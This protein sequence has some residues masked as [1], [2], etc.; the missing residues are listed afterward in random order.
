MTLAYL[1][2]LAAGPGAQADKPV[3]LDL[4]GLRQV[5]AEIET[6]GGQY[7]VKTRMLPVTVFDKTTNA[8]L[9][10]QKAEQYALQALARYLSRAR[11]SQLE[12]SGAR[13]AAT[14][15]AG[16]FYTLTLTA[17]TRGVKVVQATTAPGKIAPGKPVRV[18]FDEPFFTR[19]RDHLDTL[20]RLVAGLAADLVAA[21]E[22]VG[23]DGKGADDFLVAVADLE[24][25][26]D[27]CLKKLR[28]E[29]TGDRLLLTVER[30]EVLAALKRR[31]A[32]WRKELTQAARRH[33]KEK[34]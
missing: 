8:R 9:N 27:N 29:V 30:D 1:F 16:A 33:E 17:P 20:D 3:R 7:V 24:E 26:G 32:A 2:A 22:K 10:R 34:Q 28:K 15:Q 13:V 4:G 25:R 23:K 21:E 14:G 5:Q 6:R 12:V 19:K 31:A 18:A 11:Q